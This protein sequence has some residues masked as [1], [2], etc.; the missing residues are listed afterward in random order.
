MAHRLQTQKLMGLF[1][2]QSVFE[3]YFQQLRH[4]DWIDLDKTIINYS[5]ENTNN[6]NS[7]A[8]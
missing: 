7:S 5:D 3:C 2:H 6:N 8:T 1:R 4:T